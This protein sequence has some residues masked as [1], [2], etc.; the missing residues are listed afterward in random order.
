MSDR[1]SGAVAHTVSM[2]WILASA[3]GNVFAYA[4]AREAPPSFQGAAAAR[5]L[6]PR[7]TGLGLDGI[8]LLQDPEAD[9]PWRMEHWDADGSRTFCSNGTRA[10][11]AVPG[12]PEG[13]RLRIV[14]SG[15]AVELQRNDGGEVGLRMP[16]GPGC[17]LGEP[18]VETIEPSV[19]GWIG[20]PQLVL[21]VASVARVDL[22]ALA[23]PL[24]F[25]PA[26]PEGTNVNVLE[27]LR[28]GE[29]RI[30]SW[31]RGVEGE[32]LCCGTGCAVAGAWLAQRSGCLEWR[33]ET[34]SPDPVRISVGRIRQGA[35]EDLWLWGPVRRLGTVLP[36]G[37]L[38]LET[39]AWNG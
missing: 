9:G 36:D 23:R 31:E 15:E 39:G 33:L 37:S 24:R 34:A 14:S 19:C 29:G 25:H 17:R 26:F 10:A 28:E 1:P 20:N 6:C 30:R 27:I 32:T 11:L 2:Q 38:G 13:G 5:I 8:F 12:A 21:E 3:S 4:W 7:G 18:P 22:P 16:E 35:W